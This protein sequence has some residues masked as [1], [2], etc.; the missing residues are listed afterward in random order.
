MDTPDEQ[1]VVYRRNSLQIMSIL[2]LFTV[3]FVLVNAVVLVIHHTAGFL[4]GGLLA[5]C[6]WFVVVVYPNKLRSERM[7]W[8]V[9]HKI[10]KNI[11]EEMVDTAIAK[12][13]WE[14]S[15]FS[16]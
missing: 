12:A 14:Q 1:E 7:N 10:I 4:L 2:W 16:A 3:I 8:G 5:F 6:F 9:T 11:E 15:L 13:R